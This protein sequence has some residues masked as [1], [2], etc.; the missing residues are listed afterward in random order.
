MILVPYCSGDL[1]LGQDDAANERAY[2]LQFSGS[3]IVSA[4]VDAAARNLGLLDAARVIVSGASA[5]GIGAVAQ[6]DRVSD[7]LSSLQQTAA[8]AASSPAAAAAVAALDPTLRPLRVR[9]S[10][11]RAVSPRFARADTKFYLIPIAGSYFDGSV[12]YNGTAPAPVPFIPWSFA[13]LAKYSA[14]WNAAVPERCAAARPQDPWACIFSVASYP[15]MQTPFFAVQAQTDAIVVSLHAGL[16]EV[17]NPP[18]QTPPRPCFNTMDPCPAEPLEYL[19]GWSERMYTALSPVLDG[20][21]PAAGAFFSACLLHTEF[22]SKKP[23]IKGKNY[24]QA[25]WAWVATDATG[26]H[27][28]IDNCQPGEIFC[29]QCSA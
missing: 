6:A 29:G 19:I 28:H 13:D 20:T 11:V 14:L 21:Y 23:L 26:R 2:G 25:A 4:I 18:S 5:G 16:P 9:P 10:P 1:F 8:L 7:Q 22:E 15:T 17:W 27:V 12:T 3:R 24:L